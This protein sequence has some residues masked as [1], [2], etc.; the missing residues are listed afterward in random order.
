MGWIGSGIH[1]CI[2]TLILKII[3]FFLLFLSTNVLAQE[4][5][6]TAGYKER[7]LKA[8][9]QL[10][11]NTRPDTARV[12]ALLGVLGSAFIGRQRAEMGAY[13]EEAVYLSHKLDYP[14][15]LM[16]C[17]KWK[18]VDFWGVKKYEMAHQYFDSAIAYGTIVATR[19][20]SGQIVLK[21]GLRMLTV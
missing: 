20:P 14:E 15:G 7:K 18:G 1:S 16:A 12:N 9:L 2:N 21:N 6:I 4:N 5:T 8:L 3:L 19:L 13:F 10:E 11:K 17:Y